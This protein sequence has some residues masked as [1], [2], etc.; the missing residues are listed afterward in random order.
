MSTFLQEEESDLFQLRLLLEEV[1]CDLCRFH[2]LAKDGCRPEDVV[3]DREFHLGEPGAF[4]DMR[5]APPGAAPYFVEVKF[6]YSAETLR[7][8]L[9][10]KYGP[11][12]AAA[13]S[14]SKV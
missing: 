4:A 7:R 5:V 1:C 10:R 3:I 9:S 14:G 6:G 2:H 8:H 11:R 12:T 13:Q